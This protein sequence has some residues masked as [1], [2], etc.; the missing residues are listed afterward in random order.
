MHACRTRR[1]GGRGADLVLCQLSIA[2]SC[3]ATIV[4]VEQSA[5]PL[6]ALDQRIAV[7]RSHPLLGHAV[8]PTQASVRATS[9]LS[10]CRFSPDV[11]AL[12]TPPDMLRAF[13]VANQPFDC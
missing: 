1:L 10:A 13:V 9:A 5:E 11:A 2:S 4:E 6:P 12:L 7:G 3:S 8:A